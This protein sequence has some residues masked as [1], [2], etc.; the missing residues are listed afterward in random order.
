[1][2]W[3]VLLRGLALIV[4][5]VAIAYLFEAIGFGARVNEAWIDTEVRG[6]GAAGELL[7]I[8]AGA[9]FTAVGL[10]RQLI[11]FLGGYAFGFGI[12]TGL[13]LLATVLGCIST[14]Y[15]S[16]L[17]GRGLVRTRFA[18][19]VKKLDSFLHT[20][21]FSMTL[22]IRLLPV[23]SNLVTNLIAGV[24]SVR[25]RPF[26]AGSAIGFV[27]QTLVFALAGSGV[28]VEPALRIGL[29]VVLFVISAVLGVWLYRRYRHGK[30]IDAA[31][32]REL[33]A[34]APAR[35]RHRGPRR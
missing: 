18:G 7:F 19:R 8:S 24:S 3:R 21:P 30:S 14:F 12:G 31:M 35:A 23:G 27:P 4:S 13:G 15:Y 2:N 28:A 5:L 17:L 33:G 1:M 25:A 29:A 6:R 10:P 16:R 22:L 32:D 11:S 34:A 26:F 9:L 20:N